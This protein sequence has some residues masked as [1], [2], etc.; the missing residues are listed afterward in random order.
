MGGVIG[1]GC[2]E[3]D[4]KQAFLDGLVV[5]NNTVFSPDDKASVICDNKQMDFEQFAGSGYD[6]GSTISSKMPT[7]DEIVAMGKA[8]LAG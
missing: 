3:G 2:L 1:G 4:T 6:F 7:A 5:A 8:L